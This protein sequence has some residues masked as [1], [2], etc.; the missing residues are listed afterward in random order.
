MKQD[1]WFSVI[2]ALSMLFI[3]LISIVNSIVYIKHIAD[4]IVLP[5]FSLL[6]LKL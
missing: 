5:L 4:V 2:V 1:K 6:F 3:A